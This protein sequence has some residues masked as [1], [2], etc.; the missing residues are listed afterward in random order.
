MGYMAAH[1]TRVHLIH[2][3]FEQYD[4]NELE[5]AALYWID[6]AQNHATTENQYLG[7]IEMARSALATIIERS[8]ARLSSS[9][10]SEALDPGFARAESE[11][12]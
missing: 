9:A 11:R 5:E 7:C 3:S 1:H 2:S 6:V 12:R 8:L 10:D 4:V